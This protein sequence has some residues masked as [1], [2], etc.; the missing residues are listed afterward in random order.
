[1]RRIFANQPSKTGRIIF[2]RYAAEDVDAPPVAAAFPRPGK[3]VIAD[4]GDDRHLNIGEAIALYEAEPATGPGGDASSDELLPP[5][6]GWHVAAGAVA[7]LGGAGGAPPTLR[8]KEPT[9]TSVSPSGLSYSSSFFAV[10]NENPSQT[11]AE[12]LCTHA[13]GHA[14][15]GR[16]AVRQTSRGRSRE[17][18]TGLGGLWRL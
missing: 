15:R 16:Q 18:L 14:A 5:E 8:R 2:Y 11:R 3:W 4:A 13:C 7:L 1:M 17:E 6:T 9:G 10:I 12:S